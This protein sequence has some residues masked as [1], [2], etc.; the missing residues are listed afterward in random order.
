MSLIMSVAMAMSPLSL[1]VA[2]PIADTLGIQVWYWLGGGLC[3]L[4]GIGAFFIPVIMNVESN[5]TEAGPAAVP[6]VK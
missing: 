2:G 5:R 6:A 4:I 3:L 1:L